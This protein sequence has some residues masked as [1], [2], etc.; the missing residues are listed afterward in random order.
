M[1]DAE[2][3][4]KKLAL[5]E[6]YLRELR[7]LANPAALASDLRERRF[8][9]HTLQIAIQVVL[10]VASHIVSDDR[11]GEPETN[12]QLFDRLA[13]AGWI[14]GAQRRTLG[15]MAGFRNILV[16]GYANV[17]LAIVREVVENHLGDLE[18]FVLAVRARLQRHP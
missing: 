9:E 1:T 18:D 15:A 14:S 11:L 8:I 17:D 3:V 7:E 10:D 12:A 16:H 2:L 13:D 5:I 6:T 4:A